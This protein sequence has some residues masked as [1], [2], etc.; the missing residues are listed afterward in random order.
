M[1]GID[2]PIKVIYPSVRFFSAVNEPKTS[3]VLAL[4]KRVNNEKRSLLEFSRA[5]YVLRVFAEIL[6]ILRFSLF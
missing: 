2:R 3:D 6:L 5:K 1:S 4:V